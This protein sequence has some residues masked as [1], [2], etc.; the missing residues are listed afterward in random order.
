M[1]SG[2]FGLGLFFGVAA[3]SAQA[4]AATIA[5]S[6]VS[7]IGVSVIPFNTTFGGTPVGGLSGLD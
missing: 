1:R 3:I 7:L 5:P 2:Y 6:Q 4:S